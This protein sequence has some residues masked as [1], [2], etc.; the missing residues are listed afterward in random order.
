VLT[1][2]GEKLFWWADFIVQCDLLVGSKRYDM[3]VISDY[4]VSDVL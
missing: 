1:D 2:F 3:F 4:R